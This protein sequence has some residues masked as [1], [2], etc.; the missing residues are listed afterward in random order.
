MS[1]QRKCKVCGKL[2]PIRI[3]FGDNVIAEIEFH[4]EQGCLNIPDSP[5]DEINCKESKDD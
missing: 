5:F 1:I 4:S 2:E 3:N